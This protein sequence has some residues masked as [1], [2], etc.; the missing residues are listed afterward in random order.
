M[1]SIG[2][3]IVYPMHGAGVIDRIEEKTI[4]G[5]TRQYYVLHVSSGDMKVMIPMEKC[6]EIGIRPIIEPEEVPA[7]LEVL[8]APST[9]MSDNWNRRNRENMELL[10]TGDIKEV[11]GVVRNLLR[12]EKTKPLS[13]GEKKMLN[14]AKQILSSELILVLHKSE[15]EVESMILEAL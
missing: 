12:V 2:D 14:N 9:K 8:H 3:K 15:E 5:E 13:S 1:Y 7:V 4:L 6:Q 10:K 11:A